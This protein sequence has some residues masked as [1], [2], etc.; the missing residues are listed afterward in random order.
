MI[1]FIFKQKLIKKSKKT[2]SF[3]GI[4]KNFTLTTV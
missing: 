3:R 1:P 4:K 2:L